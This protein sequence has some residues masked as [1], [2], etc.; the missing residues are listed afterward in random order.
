MIIPLVSKPQ[1]VSFNKKKKKNLVFKTV[2]FWYLN[3]PLL[4]IK[5][6][7]LNALTQCKKTENNAFFILTYNSSLENYQSLITQGFWWGGKF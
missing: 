7:K 2:I 1:L 6:E 4:L 5:K 3:I